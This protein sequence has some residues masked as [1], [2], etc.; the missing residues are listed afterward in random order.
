MLAHAGLTTPDLAVALAILLSLAAAG[1]VMEAATP[2]RVFVGG[3]C[4]AAAILTKASAVTLVPTGLVLVLH[5]IFASRGL[6]VAVGSRRWRADSRSTRAG[7]LAGVTVAFA[8][9][10]FAVCWGAYSF[11]Y[12]P[13]PPSATAEEREALAARVESEKQRAPDSVP[14]ALL[15]WLGEE[16]LLPR[17]LIDGYRHYAFAT[18]DRPTFMR[19]AYSRGGWVTYFPYAFLAKTPLPILLAFLLGLAGTAAR[20]VGVDAPH[21]FAT[22]GSIA[23]LGAFLVVYGAT[24]L[25]SEIQIG[26]RH[27]LPMYPVLFVLAG[28]AVHWARRRRVVEVGLVAALAGGAAICAVRAWP[29][30]LSYFNALVGGSEN[31]YRLLV[32]SSVD[33]GQ[34][35]PT[36]RDRL[37]E[38]RAR[39]PER[40]VY[41]SYFGSA[42]PQYHGID[43]TRLP[44]YEPGVGHVRT[45]ISY[46][47][48]I[49]CISATMLQQVYSIGFGGWTVQHEKEYQW[50]RAI[51]EEWERRDAG[52][53]GELDAQ[54]E[55][56]RVVALGEEL[57]LAR[58]AGFLRARRPD[59]RAGHSILIYE[60]GAAD[61]ERALKGPPAELLEASAI[62]ERSVH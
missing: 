11:R 59:S 3:A 27:L 54:P 20:L 22:P 26:H 62:E 40:P 36:L 28:G 6:P 33:W 56:S 12:D 9:V 1:R 15:D 48:G 51:L 38:W 18:L 52:G 42:R 30:H 46:R 7:V 34:D 24:A 37:S 53:R 21:R 25:T 57:R 13:L 29:H 17:A 32:D 35:L 23:P 58:L 47:A 31:G 8:C 44:G 55:F 49:Y 19:G 4:F 10:G 43:A 2:A 16:R 45:P 5:G 50:H 39:D 14:I 60:L 61:L 41:L